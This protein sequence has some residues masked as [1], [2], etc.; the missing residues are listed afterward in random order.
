MGALPPQKNIQLQSI[1]GAPSWLAGLLTPLNKI[2]GALY[3]VANKGTSIGS[4]IDQQIQDLQ[5]SITNGTWIP[6]NFKCTTIAKPRGC[7]VVGITG[8]IP[9]VG[10]V[11]VNS[12][13][14]AGN[15][16]TINSLTGL[17]NGTYTITLWVLT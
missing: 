4:Q 3:D 16:I 12:W 7:Q 6:V 1:P 11:V 9:P 15:Q 13:N 10:A 5:V 8:P 14:F 17:G 2:L